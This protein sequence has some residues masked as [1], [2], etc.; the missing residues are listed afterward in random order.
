MKINKILTLSA[1]IAL[2]IASSQSM[3]ELSDEKIA[4]L[5]A[6]LTPL[7]GEVAG[8]AEGTIPAWM[9]GIRSALEAGYPDFK[10][11]GHHPDPYKDEAPLFAITAQ[12]MDEYAD[13]LTEGHKAMLAVYPD[14]AM[15]VYPAHRSAA[16]PRW[17]YDATK[18]TAVTA[19]LNESGNGVTDAVIGI[20]FPIPNNGL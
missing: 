20:P 7:G 18:T 3:A 19:R 16:F 17:I 15:K 9:G 4:E 13:K 11:G 5:G 8:N 14:F 2:F 1:I 6:N 12:N 10:P